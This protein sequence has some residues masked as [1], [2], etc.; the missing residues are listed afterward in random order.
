[1][2]RALLYLHAP[3][4][5]VLSINTQVSDW[6]LAFWSAHPD[7]T[8]R[9]SLGFYA[10]T[11]VG[12]VVT[13]AVSGLCFA[14]VSVAASKSLHNKVFASVMRAPMGWFD[15]QPVGRI[16][17]RFT[18]D[19][20]Q[21]DVALPFSLENSLDLLTQCGLAVVLIAI[22]LP[23]FLVAV[24][25]ILVIFL[26]IT[27]YFRR[28]ARELKRLEAISR[29]PLVSFVQA[30]MAGLPSI[31]AYSQQERYAEMARMVVDEQTKAY[32]WFYALNRWVG[33]R[34][35]WI[36]TLIAFITVV[37]CVASRDNLQ[38]GIAGLTVLY[39]LR[40]GGVFQFALRQLAESEA[41][42]TAVE[43][44]RYYSSGIPHEE[45][46]AAPP[47]SEKDAFDALAAAKP[48]STSSVILE[49]SAS[50]LSSSRADVGTSFTRETPQAGS[51]AVEIPRKVTATGADEHAAGG[52]AHP[53]WYPR[54][55]NQAIISSGWP[56]YGAIELRGVSVR[57]R[58]EL[59]LVLKNVS[60]SIAGGLRVGVVGRT[61]SGKTTL[62]LALMRLLEPAAG[63]VIIDGLDISRIN[64][65][66]LRSHVA[67]IPQVCMCAATV[68]IVV[69]LFGS[70]V[71]CLSSCQCLAAR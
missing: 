13:A 48:I 52:C 64:L 66:Q 17:S 22:F 49:E 3:S 31:R 1:V 69:G 35:D 16:L 71:C 57:Y 63:Q 65:Y 53:A 46:T 43:R 45:V 9:N 40:T 6:F 59:P 42:L 70:M 34:L 15:T 33:I 18:G 58:R 37:L 25:P 39:A 8:Q 47:Y 29:S 38:P 36:T 51:K 68:L 24:P 12:V 14:M 54:S 23:F 55:W 61:G 56:L 27:G 26:V 10:L 60:L 30:V 7:P 28:A 41:Y 11:V 32:F 2:L 19:L 21:V 50:A 62:S 20:D 5:S 4:R 44:L 67:V